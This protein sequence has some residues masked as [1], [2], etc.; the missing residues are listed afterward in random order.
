MHL[1]NIGFWFLWEAQSNLIKSKSN[2]KERP[3]S[4]WKSTQFVQI[5]PAPPCDGRT[6]GDPGSLGISW[7]LSWL[8]HTKQIIIS[9]WSRWCKKILI[10]ERWC[11]KISIWERCTKG[12]MGG[13]S[14]AIAKSALAAGA[15]LFA[16]RCNGSKKT[17]NNN[18]NNYAITTQ[19][20]KYSCSTN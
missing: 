14:N 3:G 13:V 12:G 7:G 8:L 6:W 16:S 4:L 10:W 17:T 5:C 15:E 19:K 11:K 20:S 18:R 2:N 9:I 1:L